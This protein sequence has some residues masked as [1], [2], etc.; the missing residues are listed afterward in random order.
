VIS[1]HILISGHVQG[2]G[3][4]SNAKRVADHFGL[5]GWVRNLPDGSV[6][7]LAEGPEGHVEEFIEWCHIGPYG[8]IVDDVIVERALAK[9]EHIGF[10]RR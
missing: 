4:R 3:F 6:E 7:I 8:A 10:Q 2:V 9:G 1:A 5:S